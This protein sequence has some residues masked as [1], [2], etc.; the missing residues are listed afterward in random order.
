MVGFGL[1]IEEGGETDTVHQIHLFWIHRMHSVM[2]TT[3][4]FHRRKNLANLSIILLSH[5]SLFKT[6]DLAVMET[7]I[8]EIFV[9]LPYVDSK[10][11]I[12]TIGYSSDCISG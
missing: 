9:P 11:S 1:S 8:Q 4:S 10:Y 5:I 6:L 3:W 7:P 12:S 2:Y